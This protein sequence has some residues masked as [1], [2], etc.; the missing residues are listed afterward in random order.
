MKNQISSLQHPIVKHLVRLRQNTDYRHEHN[1]VVIEGIKM[2]EEI[3][4]TQHF[5][6]LLTYDEAL[7]PKGL[8]ADHIYLASE[9]VMQK[10]SG[11]KTPEGILA[12]VA[13]PKP[14]DLNGKRHLI[15]IDG[16]ADPGNLGSIL[17]TALAFGW[18]GAFI[19]NE[20][21]DPYNEKALRAARGAIFRLPI[22]HGNWE[23]LQSLAQSNQLLPCVADLSGLAPEN[24][25]AS[26]GL[27]LLLGNEAHGPSP[28]TKKWCHPVSI[29]MPG[30]MESLNVAVAGGILMYLLK[31]PKY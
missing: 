28:H 26:Q 31:Q 2:I 17:R 6:A 20:S 30:E 27:L 23:Q 29:P 22:A 14:A 9:E 4:S 11:M 5:K 25:N 3:G 8:K 10:A 1:S 15:G 24:I 19:L 7:I 18:E 13:M 16:V 21:C 12:E